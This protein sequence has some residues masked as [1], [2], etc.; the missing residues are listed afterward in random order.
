[1]SSAIGTGQMQG[2]LIQRPEFSNFFVIR[3]VKNAD[4]KM[5]FV[6]LQIF[7]RQCTPHVAGLEGRSSPFPDHLPHRI[8]GFLAEHIHLRLSLFE[9]DEEYQSLLDSA[10]ATCCLTCRLHRTRSTGLKSTH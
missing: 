3:L 4:Y 1:M 6:L 7:S 5:R 2:Y 10:T 8:T 9:K